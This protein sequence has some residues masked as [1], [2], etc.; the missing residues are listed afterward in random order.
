MKEK[1][2]IKILKNYEGRCSKMIINSLY[3]IKFRDVDKELKY[4]VE[5]EK[6]MNVYK[7]D[8]GYRFCP[9][10][11]NSLTDEKYGLTYKIS[12]CFHC[13]QHLKWGEF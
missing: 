9:K 10:C 5:K 1:D 11:E 2:M 8:K 6:P 3:G 4:L 12:Y 7:D 13:G